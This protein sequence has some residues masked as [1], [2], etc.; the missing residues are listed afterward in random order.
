MSANGNGQPPAGATDIGVQ[1]LEGMLQSAAIVTSKARGT[2]S[3]AEAKDFAQSALLF[4]QAIT[5]LDPTRI[6]NGNDPDAKKASTP[7]PPVRD[8]DRD[9]KTG[10]S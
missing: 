10:E 5:T 3:A 9:G 2:D 7:T 6:D 4:A 1:L 8:T